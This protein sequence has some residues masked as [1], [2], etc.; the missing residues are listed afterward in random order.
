MYVKKYIKNLNNNNINNKK[1]KNFKS[2]IISC[3]LSQ[4]D[5]KDSD[6]IFQI[7]FYSYLSNKSWTI[8]RKLSDFSQYSTLMEK[9]Y[10]N[11]PKI[12]SKINQPTR[13]NTELNNKKI[14]FENY[15]QV[16]I[17]LK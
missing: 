14:V 5:Q 15:I 9:F 4:S 10:V 8:F 16:N 12:P 1:N 2:E 6:A 11:V 13:I 7:E 17:K 3:N